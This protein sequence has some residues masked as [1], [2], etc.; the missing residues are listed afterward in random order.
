MSG[1]EALSTFG[2][3]VE[4][5]FLVRTIEELYENVHKLYLCTYQIFSVL[6]CDLSTIYLPFIIKKTQRT[7]RNGDVASGLKWKK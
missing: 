1:R 7:K 3:I 4:G 6:F 5:V 2:F